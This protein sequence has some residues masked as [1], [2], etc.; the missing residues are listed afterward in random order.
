MTNALSL[1]SE[2]TITNRII[3]APKLPSHFAKESFS[4]KNFLSKTFSSVTPLTLSI[5]HF[6]HFTMNTGNRQTK[7]VFLLQL[8]L[9]Y[10]LALVKSPVQFL[11][12]QRYLFYPQQ[13]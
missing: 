7:L 3:S 12:T 4:A 10:N 11:H 9:R 2:V 1:W 6:F 8:M 5:S 13:K